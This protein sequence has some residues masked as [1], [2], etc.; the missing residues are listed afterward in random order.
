MDEPNVKTLNELLRGEHMA[1]HSY[2]CV[3]P[4]LTEDTRKQIDSILQDHK[5]HAAELADRITSLGG[6]P[7]EST[8]MAGMM[9]RAKL[10]IESKLQDKKSILKELYD[11]ENKGIALVEQIIKGDLDS[12]SRE[13]VDKILRTDKEHLKKLE[14]M[15][16]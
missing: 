6:I 13:M 15:I 3:M 9:S 12:D 10:K 11:G 5:N 7:E 14:R 4:S 16:H 2:E 8:G 1:I